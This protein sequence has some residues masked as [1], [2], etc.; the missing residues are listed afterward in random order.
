MLVGHPKG[1]QVLGAVSHVRCAK[2]NRGILA[3]LPLCFARPQV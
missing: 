3:S 1:G 2:E